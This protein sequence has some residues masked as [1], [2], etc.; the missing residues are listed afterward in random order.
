MYI[1][2]MEQCKENTQKL[3]ALLLEHT[4]IPQEYYLYIWVV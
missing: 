3:I 1:S 4:S 2:Y